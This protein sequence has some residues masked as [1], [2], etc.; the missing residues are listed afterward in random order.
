MLLAFDTATP[1]VTVALHDGTH[2]LAETTAI[3]ARRHGE[4]LAAAI[5][6]LLAGAGASRRDITAV[7][8]G[9]GPGPYTG[10]RAGLVTARVLGSALGVPVY[11]VCTLDVIAADA[12]AAAGGR[13]FLVATDARRREVYWARYDAAGARL[14]GPDVGRPA[15]VAA[16]AGPVPGRGHRAGALPGPAGGGDRARLPVGRH[17]GPPGRRPDRRGHGRR[18]GR[19]G[20]PAPSGRPGARAAQAGDRVSAGAADRVPAGAAQVALRPMTRADLP[21]VLGLEHALFGE[22]AWTEGM[23]ASELGGVAS[24]RYY[25]VAEDGGEVIGYAGL[26]TPGGGQADVLTLAVTEQRWGRRVGATLL[27]ALI[28]EAARRGCTEVFLEVRIDNERAQRLYAGRGFT[29]IGVRRGYYQPSGT[30]ALVMRLSL[31]RPAAAAWPGGPAARQEVPGE[32]PAGAR[33]RD[34]LRRDRRRAGPRA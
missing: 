12:A 5:E 29:E 30:D 15:D 34:L 6:A 32:R 27:D 26:L 23:L 16:A 22:E 3:D 10:L 13:E 9:T 24:G 20:L 25:L 21:A 4:L 17:P 19:P 8:S 11:G 31:P 7:A 33:H 14:A 28:S 1:A 2:V 18:R